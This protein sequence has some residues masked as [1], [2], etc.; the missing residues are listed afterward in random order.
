MIIWPHNESTTVEGLSS[1]KA[2]TAGLRNC[3]TLAPNTRQS[4]PTQ[5][6]QSSGTDCSTADKYL[7]SW[8]RTNTGVNPNCSKTGSHIGYAGLNNT[9]GCRVGLGKMT[10]AAIPRSASSDSELCCGF[11]RLTACGQEVSSGRLV[12][13]E[14]VGVVVASSCLPIPVRPLGKPGA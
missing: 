14:I 2:V 11:G 9:Q 8:R 7:S 1:Q 4:R 12:K 3:G 10:P 5:I 13:V 6:V